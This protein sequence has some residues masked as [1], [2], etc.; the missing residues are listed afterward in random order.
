MTTYTNP[1][2]L[3]DSLEDIKKYEVE[4]EVVDYT[5]KRSVYFAFIDVLGFKKTFDD[6]RLIKDDNCADK[7][8]K[9]FTYYFDLMNS[10]NFSIKPQNPLC[11]AGQTSD[12][13]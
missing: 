6:N 5:A 13:L 1:I 9:V 7:F 8:R 4:S 12:S 2:P 3:V 11:Y 10:A